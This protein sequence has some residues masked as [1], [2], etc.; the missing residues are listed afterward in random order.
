MYCYD[1]KSVSMERRNQKDTGYSGG[2][3]WTA[4]R[5]WLLQS[6]EGQ[7]DESFK[8]CRALLPVW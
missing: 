1:D 6:G 2:M 8:F 3:G 4:E 5:R 7:M